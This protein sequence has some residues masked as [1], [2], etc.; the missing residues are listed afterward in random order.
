MLTNDDGIGAPGIIAMHDALLGHGITG[1][2]PLAKELMVVAPLTVQSA[3]G[4][5]VTFRTPLM[6]KRARLAEHG[7]LAVA[8]GAE[9]GIGLAVDGRPADCTKLGV[10]ALWPERFGKGAG[11]KPDV[12]ISGMNMGCNVGINVLYSGTVAAA[13]EAAFLGVPAI[14]V[15]LH[16]GK[17]PADYRLAAR[18]A[19][20]VIRRIMTSGGLRAHEC[21]SI[22]LPRTT[23]L[24]ADAAM[25]LVAVC[26]MNT[27]GSVD[28]FTRHTS[29]MGEVYYWSTGSPTDFHSTEEGSDVEHLMAG[30]ITVTPITYDMTDRS[31][32]RNWEERIGGEAKWPS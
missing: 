22:N 27:H 23:G 31:G 2:L 6:T 30:R 18:W 20:D 28:A 29:P 9:G 19:I 25:P 5:G 12:V 3:A 10:A 7:A 15:S 32:M 16:L 24:G 11:A 14:A 1:F 17:E 21:V 8:P 26:P 13:V 4:H